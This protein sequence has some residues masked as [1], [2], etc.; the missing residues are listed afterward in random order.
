MRGGGRRAEEGE[1]GG[2]SGRVEGFIS[3]HSLDTSVVDRNKRSDIR[4][5]ST[6]Q[7]L[8]R[9]R[10]KVQSFMEELHPGAHINT[11]QNS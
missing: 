11:L 9:R 3:M 10:G 5:D 4:W 2:G 6:H 7:R 1:A 8:W